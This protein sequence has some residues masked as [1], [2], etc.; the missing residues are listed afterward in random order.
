MPYVLARHD[1]ILVNAVEQFGG[2]VFS[3]G[4]DGMAV[5]FQR[6]A[7]A[8]SAAIDAQRRLQDDAT[9]STPALGVRMGIHTGEAEERDGNYF[10]PP[11]NR[12][13]RLMGIARGGQI[14]VSRATAEVIGYLPGLQLI[15]AG[16]HRLKG[17]SESLHLFEVH[18]P[19][20]GLADRD[21]RAP[22][23]LSPGPSAGTPASGASSV[24]FGI[25][26]GHESPDEVVVGRNAEM[27][28]LWAWWRQGSGHRVMLVTGESGIGKTRLVRAFARQVRAEGHLAVYGQAMQGGGSGYE[29]VLGALRQYVSAVDERTIRSWSGST[30]TALARLVPEVAQRRTVGTASKGSDDV[31]RSWLLTGV[32]DS[33]A[34]PG[35][36]VLLV[37]DDLQW[38][39]RAASLLLAHLARVGSR[40]RILGTYRTG[41]ASGHLQGL[42]AEL[43]RDDRVISRLSLS[44]LDPNEVADYMSALTGAGLTDAGRALA[45]LLHRR[46]DGHPFFVR[47][48]VRH[49]QDAG[50]F[51]PDDGAWGDADALDR[52]G[53]PEGVRDVV[54][55]RLGRL[56]PVT[57]RL[58]DAAAVLGAVFDLDVA[59]AVADAGEADVMAAV[60][61]AVAAEVVQEDPGRV[62]RYDFGHAI[63][64]EVVLAELSRSRRAR[65]EWRA[66]VALERLRPMQLDELAADIARHL[67]AGRAIGDAQGAADWCRRAGELA[68]DRLAYE[69]AIRFFEMALAAL[70]DT[71]EINDG[72]RADILTVVGRAANRAGD[73][74]RWAE[75][76]R[77]A[78]G[79]AR[80]AGDP[81]RL[82]RAA[83]SLLG[84]L[85]P[86]VLD[87]RV[88]A[89]LGEAADGLR[90]APVTPARAALRAEVLARSSGYLINA[91]PERAARLA[92]EAL[93]VASVAGDPRSHALALVYSS[94]THTLRREEHLSRLRRAEVLAEEAGDNE[95]ALAV[96]S[97]L[98]VGALTWA[99]R[100]EFDR[101]L[102]AYA[103]VAEAMRATTPLVLSAIDHASASALDGHYQRAADQLAEASRRAEP[104]GDPF[105]AELIQTGK[106]PV[107]RELGQLASRVDSVR[108][109]VQ[110]RP[111]RLSFRVSLVRVLCEA[112]ERAEATASL[113]DLLDEPAEICSGYLRRMNFA[114]LAEAAEQLGDLDAAETIY[115]WLK[116]ELAH[117]DC[118]TVGANSFY[119]AVHRYLGLLTATRGRTDDAVGHYRSAIAIHDQM[120]AAGWAARTRYDLARALLVRP[121]RTATEVGRELLEQASRSAIQLGMTRLIAELSDL[122]QVA[123][124]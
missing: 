93:T 58:L 9:T 102:A 73:P 80:R 74:E 18:A 50:V 11:L 91:Q 25:A 114:F 56:S 35:P 68:I 105:L 78:A 96:H 17:L 20:L 64:Q 40:A 45:R 124:I 106:F 116:A 99:D 34:G 95:V 24:D 97:N 13:S 87:D 122:S 67:H 61:E 5:A 92:D 52:H 107:W 30:A 123:E 110:R 84:S 48:T 103:R 53:V 7:D 111:D 117:G 63:V 42:L 28:A 47:E 14:L 41:E 46:T 72:P 118:I 36:P 43:R 26:D 79:A 33:L 104:L 108:R 85:G 98:M 39:G 49:L 112:G 82:A 44:G 3:S 15:D 22:E 6:S 71:G 121:S 38:A 86:G 19:G 4:G 60:E 32:A 77:A 59:A 57:R 101:H 8:V 66:G 51:A 115:P 10:G 23:E 76:C 75:S 69:D 54:A 1:S 90:A 88:V 81:E 113:H 12:V 100:D 37:L 16:E 31:D 21:A 94:Q 89:L 29:P 2:C 62:D 109:A 120:R 65:L 83:I 70:D 27:D 55:E 119:G